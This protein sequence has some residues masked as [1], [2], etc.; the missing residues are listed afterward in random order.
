MM[1]D[2]QEMILPAPRPFFEWRLTPAGPALVCLALEPLA[3]HLFTTRHW[4][5]GTRA[6]RADESAL[7]QP[8]AQ[9]IDVHPEKLVRVRQVHGTTTVVAGP[10]GGPAAR[11]WWRRAPWSET[12]TWFRSIAPRRTSPAMSVVCS[13]VHRVRCTSL[14]HYCSEK[15]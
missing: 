11:P 2:M 1:F 15:T 6:A 13:W 12:W 8:V 10:H 3:A 5:L 7:W 4:T 14:R 9:V